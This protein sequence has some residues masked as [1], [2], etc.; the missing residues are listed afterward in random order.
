MDRRVLISG[1][2]IAGLSCAYW[3]HRAGWHVTVI[4]RAEEFRT[5][6]QNVDIRGE[7]REVVRLMGIED[8]IRAA[9]TTEE[10]TVFVDADDR[11]VA[12]FPMAEDGEGL[13]ADMEILRGDLALILRDALPAGVGLRVGEEI[14]DVADTGESVE[15][16]FASGE[17]STYD[18]L[19]VAEGVRSRTRDRLFGPEVERKPLRLT[20]VYGTIARRGDD[21]RWWHWYTAT[22]GRQVTTRPDGHGT[23]RATMSY[24]SAEGEG[25]AGASREE[26]VATLRRRFEGAGWQTERVLDGF[27]GSDDVYAD[28]LEQI[29]MVSWSH[30]RVC[31]VGDAAWCPTPLGGGGSSLAIL[32]GYVLGAALSRTVTDEVTPGGLRQALT[33]Y[34]EWL[35]PDV[36]AV[37]GMPPGVVAASHPRSRVGVFL[38]RTALKVGALPPVRAIMSKL[39]SDDVREL[40]R[41]R[42]ER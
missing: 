27:A 37:H 2:S 30:G 15:V 29:R 17:R 36:D 35:R 6:G 40:P 16:R 38:N 11:D 34:E 31:L 20:M 26:L 25:L 10:G 1:A 24:R 22:G 12:R 14:E 13:T 5:G 3:L 41:G 19:V 4:E 7:A 8:A 9:T 28:D 21:D 32:S 33:E 18:L 39:T 23:T 42:F